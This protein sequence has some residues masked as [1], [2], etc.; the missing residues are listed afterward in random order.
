MPVN[1]KQSSGVVLY[2]REQ[3]EKGGIS[4]WYW[5]YK[6][7]IVLNEINE[8]YNE[9]VD[10]G[11]GEGIMLEKLTR[12]FPHKNIV[13][14]DSMAE[15]VQICS[16]RGL[17]IRLG[18]VYFLDFPQDSVDLVILMEVIEH[19]DDPNKAIQEIYKILKPGGKLIIVFPNDTTFI[20]ARILTLKL[21]EAVYNPGHL[22]QWNPREVR[23]LLNSYNLDVIKSLSI[24][25]F[26]WPISLHTVTIAIKIP[27]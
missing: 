6:D 3:Y 14:L 24:P 4:R 18:D 9:I 19:L 21:K 22:K 1:E 27:A 25:F 8:E 11:C 17:Q 7:N 20:V 12:C 13:G 15:N 26:W 2:Q 10:I 5:D 16:K 23:S